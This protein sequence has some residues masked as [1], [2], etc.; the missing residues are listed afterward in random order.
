[1]VL[2]QL[3]SQENLHVQRATM[4]G[5]I[6]SI[7]SQSLQQLQAIQSKHVEIAQQSQ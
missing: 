6:V 7:Q 3:Q 2:L 4:Y 1:M 5:N